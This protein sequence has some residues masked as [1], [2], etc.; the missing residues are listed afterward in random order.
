MCTASTRFLCHAAPAPALEVPSAGYSFEWTGISHGLGESLALTR[1]PMPWLGDGVT[2][3]EGQIAI[4][5]KVVGSNLG[6]FFNG[7]VA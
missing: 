6:Y 2:R 1:I 5:Q 4:D 7:A 3:I